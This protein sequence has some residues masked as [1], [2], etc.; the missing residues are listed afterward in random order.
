MKQDASA[1]VS[2]PKNK[3]AGKLNAIGT[4]RY[5][6]SVH[7][8]CGHLYAMGDDAINPWYTSGWGFTWVPFFMMLSG[9]ILTYARLNS[10]DPSKRESRFSFLLKRLRGIYPLYLTGLLARMAQVA[11]LDGHSFSLGTPVQ[12]VLSLTLT[13]AWAANEITSV[14]QQQCWFLSCI[15]PYWFFHQD[16]YAVAR[17]TKTLVL[18]IFAALVCLIP[19]LGFWL[20]PD[21]FEDVSSDWYNVESGQPL[22][23]LVNNPS[24]TT[25][26][27]RNY[28]KFHPVFYFHIYLFGIAMAVLMQRR[29][30]FHSSIQFIFRYGAVIG[31]FGLFGVFLLS[32]VFTVPGYKLSCRLG[33][34]APLQGLYLIG[35]SLGKDPVARLFG[36]RVLAPL[37]NLSYAQYIFQF[38]AFYGW[39]RNGNTIDFWIWLTTLSMLGYAWVQKPLKSASIP[40][41]KQ[42]LGA[43]CTIV[44]VPGIV[45]L[46]AFSLRVASQNSQQPS[47]SAHRALMSEDPYGDFNLSKTIEGAVKAAGGLQNGEYL[48]NPALLYDENEQKMFVAVREHSYNKVRSSQLN[49]TT[50]MAYNSDAV[51]KSRVFFGQVNPDT[52]QPIGAFVDPFKTSAGGEQASQWSACTEF[53]RWYES[54]NRE[55]VR[56]VASGFEDPRFIHTTDSQHA[57]GVLITTNL[58][59]PVHESL[60][61]I[62][63]IGRRMMIANVT[64]TLDS[65]SDSPAENILLNS[66]LGHL[67]AVDRVTPEKNWLGFIDGKG[68]LLM[69]N[70]VIPLKVLRPVDAETI[71]TK[72]S[73]R[74]TRAARDG[75]LRTKQDRFASSNAT[76]AFISNVLQDKGVKV[77]GG[78]N[79]IKYQRKVDH[80]DVMLSC[81]HL[82]YPSGEYE[83]YL[84]EFAEN[85][86]DGIYRLERISTALELT[87]QPLKSNSG[88]LAPLAFGSA[89]TRLPDNQGL[90][91]GYGS[92]NI[93]ARVRKFSWNAIEK[94]FGRK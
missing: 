74:Q 86:N 42:A 40:Y 19:L 1:Q 30:Q 78:C 92:S 33:A 5:I 57:K 31:L 52:F 8:V 44:V 55:F 14:L 81:F 26:T 15:V 7:I 20:I 70:S 53:S 68:E 72:S 89:L 87:K 32:A 83:N 21:L 80:K 36:L 75:W 11:V 60:E 71:L 12:T 37:E 69:I 88:A 39:P 16:A 9:F 50:V 18:L 22:K 61:N 38:I 91:L 82:L 79:P 27:L 76:E 4:A 56:T 51:W 25:M 43:F 54:S 34:L 24:F 64:H 62:C 13:Q 17:K 47:N 66:P 46:Q 35:L 94:L 10:R 28:L 65:S 84:F 23:H 73:E 41:K 29:E 90:A 77:H 2:Q 48:I 59:S 49:Q 58:A 85:E 6:A 67:A 3:K 93:E 63:D 45:A